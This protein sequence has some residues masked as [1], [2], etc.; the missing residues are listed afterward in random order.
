MTVLPPMH[1]L[2]AAAADLARAAHAAGD[3][4]NER[5]IN[6]A[7]YDL[8]TGSVPMETTGGYLVP[9]HTRAMA[10]RVSDAYGCSCEAGSHGKPCR[11]A[12][13]IEIIAAARG[14]VL[15]GARLAARR[16]ELLYLDELY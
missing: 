5:A 4:A 1:V 13:Q 2:A 7:D 10:H 6:N 12:A 11:H 3:M 9:S 16:W 14:R 8:H 15:L